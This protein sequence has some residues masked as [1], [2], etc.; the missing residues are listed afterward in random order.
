[1]KELLKSGLFE[2]TVL[3]RESSTHQF[4]NGV[5]VVKVDYRNV[6]ALT[7]ALNGQD[8]LVSAVATNA[9]PSQRQLIEAAVEAGVKRII[10]SEYVRSHNPLS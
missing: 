3:T 4:P 10:P 8:A 7:T 6:E 2:I 9:V 5:K 1:M